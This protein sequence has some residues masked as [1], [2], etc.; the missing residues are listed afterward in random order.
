MKELRTIDH[1]QNFIFENSNLDLSQYKKTI[2]YISVEKHRAFDLGYE[3]LE[4]KLSLTEILPND[5][6][7]LLNLLKK[8][9]SDIQT[10]KNKGK[11]KIFFASANRYECERQ[12]FLS[13]E[14]SQDFIMK[15]ISKLNDL[16]D[17]FQ[18]SISSEL[19]LVSEIKDYFKESY[20]IKNYGENW[21]ETLSEKALNQ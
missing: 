8:V 10:L 13:I 18:T 16:N 15:E 12:C 6:D 21:M 11:I 5:K 1:L 3:I 20:L 14:E 9:D 17:D 19:I 4:N 2:E 7:F